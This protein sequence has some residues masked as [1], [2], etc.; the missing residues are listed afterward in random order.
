MLECKPKRNITIRLDE[1]EIEALESL[2]LLKQSVI[3][4]SVT[5][6]NILADCIDAGFEIVGES[7]LATLQKF[8]ESFQ[9]ADGDFGTSEVAVS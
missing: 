4:L 6:S 2:R 7:L 3:G 5:R 8:Q 1:E 9:P